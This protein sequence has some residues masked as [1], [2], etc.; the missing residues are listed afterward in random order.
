M[1]DFDN[2]P[3]VMGSIHQKNG[4]S[5]S[6]IINP[7]FPGALFD[8]PVRYQERERSRNGGDETIVVQGRKR[9]W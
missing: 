4:P 5:A 6:R 2:G 3:L 8:H 9:F 7:V 1:N